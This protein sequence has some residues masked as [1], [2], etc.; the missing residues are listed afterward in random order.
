MY[1]CC[2]NLIIRTII[3]LTINRHKNPLTLAP[4]PP[5]A[6][7]FFKILPVRSSIFFEEKMRDCYLVILRYQKKIN[8]VLQQYKISTIGPS[9]LSFVCYVSLYFH[10][11][12]YYIL[13]FI[14]IT[15]APS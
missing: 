15:V 10:D 2:G 5:H 9:M 8:R 4:P 6:I 11:S 12:I 13:F 3:R 7:Y 14:K 1:R